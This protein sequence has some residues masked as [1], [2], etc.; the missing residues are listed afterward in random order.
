M[1]QIAQF[2]ILEVRIKN[3]KAKQWQGSQP[4]GVS[5]GSTR[6]A[7]LQ[8]S[9]NNTAQ[10]LGRIRAAHPSLLSIVLEDLLELFAHAFEIFKEGGSSLL[11]DISFR[12]LA[13]FRR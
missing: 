13:W 11:H 2:N 6:A 9:G 5:N 1:G 3:W 8:P 4:I 12:V 10:K 7:Q